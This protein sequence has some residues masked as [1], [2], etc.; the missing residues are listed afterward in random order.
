MLSPMIQGIVNTSISEGLVYAFVAIGVFLTLR[1]LAFPDL[2]V[3]GSFV[4]G[5]SLAAVMIAGGCNPFLGSY[6]RLCR[7]ISLWL[8]NWVA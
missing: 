7:R 1:V 4:V 3:D 2:T 6:S 5:G 8:H